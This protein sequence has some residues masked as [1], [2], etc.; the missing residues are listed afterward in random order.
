MAKKSEIKVVD[1]NCI[2]LQKE[3]GELDEMDLTI[4]LA[5]F[6]SK[7]LKMFELYVSRVICDL[8]SQ[9]GINIS[10]KPTK[11]DILKLTNSS[12]RL[13]IKDIYATTQEKIVYR[14]DKETIIYYDGFLEV[15]NE[16]VENGK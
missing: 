7:D 16:V 11:D 15:A 6:I 13:E 5:K 3:I 4:E 14:Q 12:Y 1:G 9:H 10:T 8:Y 2:I